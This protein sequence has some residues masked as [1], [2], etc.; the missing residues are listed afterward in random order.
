MSVLSL[1]GGG[2]NPGLGRQRFRIV[3]ADVFPDVGKRHFGNARRIG[4]HIRN[5]TDPVGS[6]IDAFIELLRNL[7]RFTRRKSQPVGGRLL[8]S[9]GCKRRFGFLLF[10]ADFLFGNAKRPQR[11]RAGNGVDFGFRLC[12]EFFILPLDE[13]GF[14][15][16]L[17]FIQKSVNRPVLLRNKIFDFLLPFTNQPQRHGLNAA[18]RETVFDLCPQNRRKVVTDQPVKDAAAFL[19]AHLVFFDFPRMADR[20]PDGVGSDFIENNPA[21][22]FTRK[23]FQYRIADVKGNRLSFAVVIAGQQHFIRA[24]NHRQ[25]FFQPRSFTA[26]GDVLRFEIMFHIDGHPRFR[27]INQMAH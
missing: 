13:R 4:S 2:I 5:Q 26:D 7:H 12:L 11:N 17:S 10:F 22:R 25:Q 8:K 18:G 24:G 3:F 1:L 6:D 15:R 14:E 19:G 16:R 20:F 23:F 9:R 27:Q 21:D